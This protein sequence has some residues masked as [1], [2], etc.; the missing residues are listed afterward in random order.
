MI[1]NCIYCIQIQHRVENRCPVRIP[2]DIGIITNVAYIAQTSAI[3][4]QDPVAWLVIR[5]VP[6]RSI[7][8]TILIKITHENVIVIDCGRSK[9]IERSQLIYSSELKDSRLIKN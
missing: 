7:Q 3:A 5:V 2:F 9:L 1:N 6:V 8:R 4:V